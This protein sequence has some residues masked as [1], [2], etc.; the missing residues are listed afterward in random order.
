M[1]FYLEILEEEISKRLKNFILTNKK[2]VDNTIKNELYSL[3]SIG[4]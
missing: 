3:K 1:L 4:H 2:D